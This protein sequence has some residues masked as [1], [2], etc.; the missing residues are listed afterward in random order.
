MLLYQH[1]NVGEQDSCIAAHDMAEGQPFA[2]VASLVTATGNT[3]PE[4]NFA[5]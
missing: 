1:A 2:P 3:C 5:T 4:I